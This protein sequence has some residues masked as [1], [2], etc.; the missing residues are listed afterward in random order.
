M[1]RDGVQ[2]EVEASGLDALQA[3]IYEKS[4]GELFGV[5]RQQFES[6]LGEIAGKYLPAA[7]AQNQIR[8]LYI[9]LRV[10]EL[11]LARACAAGHEHAWEV[12]LTRY[13]EKLYDI[14]G[15]ITKES[16]AARELA[17][18]IYADSTAPQPATASAPRS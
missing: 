9:S 5:T 8:E 4:R 15:Y 7:P 3:A 16:S 13:R 14:A 2:S 10:E 1:S 11:A 6:I 18:S 12:F 17:D